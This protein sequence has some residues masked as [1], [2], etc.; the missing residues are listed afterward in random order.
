[1]KLK[2]TFILLLFA[3]CFAALAAPQEQI[4]IINPQQEIDLS[5]IYGVQ[6]NYQ[7][8]QNREIELALFDVNGKK[9]GYRVVLAPEG[10]AVAEIAVPAV[11]VVENGEYTIVASLRKLG[12]GMNIAQDKFKC[13]AVERFPAEAVNLVTLPLSI[14]LSG[15]YKFKV[16]YKVNQLRDIYVAVFAN[17]WK[18]FK[19]EGRVN[20]VKGQGEVVVPVTS[21]PFNNGEKV[22]II[23]ELRPRGGNWGSRLVSVSP[24]TIA[25]DSKKLDL[26]ETI[27]MVSSP[28]TMECTGEYTV[29]VDYQVATTRSLLLVLFDNNWKYLSNRTK[30]LHAG[31]GTTSLTVRYSK[32]KPG[33][34]YWTTVMLCAEKDVWKNIIKKYHKLVTVSKGTVS[35]K[36]P[37]TPLAKGGKERLEVVTFPTT[38]SAD[39]EYTVVANYNVAQ[40]RMIFVALFDEKWKYLDEVKVLVKGKGI[41]RLGLKSSKVKTGQ[42]YWALT[43]LCDKK[44]KWKKII[45]KEKQQLLAK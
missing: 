37:E 42:K 12:K 34:K 20:G 32:V 28:K 35:N 23:I 19:G 10:K 29:K 38:I 21:T 1:M 39:N 45:K 44:D 31:K 15:K 41:C 30:T 16:K 26:Q 3:G 14:N 2:I 24:K 27:K 36:A 6:V 5:G 22:Q 4:K 43:V 13:K 7:A 18:N 40:E 17:G 9:C 25:L 11:G 33:E 8:S